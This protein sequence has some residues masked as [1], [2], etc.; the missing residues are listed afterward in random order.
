MRRAQRAFVAANAVPLV[1]G[2]ALSLLTA[3]PAVHVYGHVTLGLVWG[4]LQCGLFV[5]GLYTLGDL[6]SLRAAGRAS[7]T[8]AALV[9]L[10]ITI[11]L[12]MVQL[13]ATGISVALLIGRSNHG[14]QVV[15][16]VLM[17]LLVG[18][19]AVVADLR[20]TSFMQVVKVVVTL[21]TLSLITLLPSAD[22]SGTPGICSPRRRRRACRRTDI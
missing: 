2:I 19:F 8:A 13:R 18:F 4:I 16:T 14:T 10:A 7:R 12:L 22:S 5:S 17:G 3:V 1:V 11:P 21:I 6:F 20:G 15:C 9:T